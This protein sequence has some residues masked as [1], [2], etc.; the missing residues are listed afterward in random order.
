MTRDGQ[1]VVPFLFQ[2]ARFAYI[3]TPS[4]TKK[5]IPGPG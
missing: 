5:F 2:K 3:F 4:F 1:M